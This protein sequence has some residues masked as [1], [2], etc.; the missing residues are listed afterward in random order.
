MHNCTKTSVIKLL[1]FMSRLTFLV[2]IATF[3]FTGVIMASG[4]R[5]Q[6]LKTVR[7]SVEVK[8]TT[9][10]AVLEQIKKKS[11]FSFV[12]TEEIG[13]IQG[14]SLSLNQES[15]YDVLKEISKDKEL[16][17]DQS[18]YLIAVIKAPVKP[19]QQPGRISGKVV[20]ERGEGLPGASIKIVE[21]GQSTQTNVDGTYVIIT[22]P[23]KT[24]CNAVPCR[25]FFVRGCLRR[26]A[27][28][29]ARSAQT[30]ARCASS[31]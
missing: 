30:G 17:F 3:T 5:S 31:R 15:L 29:P 18:N 1:Y 28:A 9:L 13:N 26:R 25:F 11:G 23:G 24:R 19:V 8:N 16:I 27:C 14:I 2:I 10:K 6:N 7:L 21:T 20:D 4:V 22:K 12:Y